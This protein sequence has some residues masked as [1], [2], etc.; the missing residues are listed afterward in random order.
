MTAQDDVLKPCP[1]CGTQ[2]RTAE[3]LTSFL[4]VCGECGASSDYYSRTVSAIDAWNRRA[5]DNRAIAA[6]DREEFLMRALRHVVSV[7]VT[8]DDAWDHDATTQRYMDY[9]I[10]MAEKAG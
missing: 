7:Y 10:G 8:D 2:P 3:D 4:V 5:P 1:F 6:I 9:F